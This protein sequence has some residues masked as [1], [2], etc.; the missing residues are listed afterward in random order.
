M[1]GYIRSIA[2]PFNKIKMYAPLPLP[3]PSLRFDTI[4]AHE[5]IGVR[6]QME[7]TINL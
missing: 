2:P 3:P 4:F 1:K 6:F 7:D 5:I